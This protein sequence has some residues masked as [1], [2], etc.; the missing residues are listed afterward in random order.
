MIFFHIQFLIGIIMLVGTSGFM[1]TIKAMGMGG[2][3]KNSALRFTYIE[4]PFSMLIAAVLMT[5]LN[6]KVKANYTITMGMVVLAV[7]A[8][9]L[10]A[11]ALPWAKLMGA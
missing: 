11:F 4:H 3:M 5:I 7:L 10:F 6:K 2:L 9:A 1:D 8:I